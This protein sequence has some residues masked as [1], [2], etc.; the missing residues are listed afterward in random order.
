[1][2]SEEKQKIN[3]LFDTII[4]ILIERHTPAETEAHSMLL[5]LQDNMNEMRDLFLYQLKDA[6]DEAMELAESFLAGSLWTKNHENLKITEEQNNSITIKRSLTFTTSDG[7]IF[8]EQ[9]VLQVLAQEFVPFIEYYHIEQLTQQNYNEIIALF[10][11][12]RIDD[13]I[14]EIQ[15]YRNNRVNSIMEKAEST[16]IDLELELERIL[17]S[18][19][20]TLYDESLSLYSDSYD[21]NLTSDYDSFEGKELDQQNTENLVSSASAFNFYREAIGEADNIFD[22]EKINPIDVDAVMVTAIRFIDYSDIPLEYTTNDPIL[23]VL[24]LLEWNFS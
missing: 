23:A 4:N 13:Y 18:Q 1:M 3:D 15:S 2:L 10:S 5:T 20:Y 7:E 14:R 24:V 16:L 12:D 17:F 19:Y 6:Y 22:A 9:D 11:V 21:D 8:T